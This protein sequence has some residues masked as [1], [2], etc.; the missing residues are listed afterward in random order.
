MWRRNKTH[1]E[2]K[3]V[4]QSHGREKRKRVLMPLIVI[5]L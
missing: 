2:E 5:I 4:N 1:T 3:N